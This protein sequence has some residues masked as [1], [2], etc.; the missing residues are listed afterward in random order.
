MNSRTETKPGCWQIHLAGEF[1]AVVKKDTGEVVAK[2]EQKILEKTH[3][4]LDEIR[5]GGM[6]ACPPPPPHRLLH[7]LVS[8]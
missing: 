3:T 6:A 2:T 7:L 5:Y 8:P 1:A 4:L